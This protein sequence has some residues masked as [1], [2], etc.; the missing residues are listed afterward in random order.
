MSCPICFER[1]NTNDRKPLTLQP[2][3]H[4]LCQVCKLKLR[5]TECPTCR[6]QFTSETPNFA[7]MEVMEQMSKSAE[8]G[9]A[10]VSVSEAPP[11]VPA[12]EVRES[13]E[14]YSTITKC[15]RFDV[16]I[17]GSM[18]WENSDNIVYKNGRKLIQLTNM[19]I[20][21]RALKLF[22]S[23]LYHEIQRQQISPC[24]VTICVGNHK[25]KTHLELT[26][27]DAT[28]SSYATIIRSIDML[29]A[30]GATDMQPWIEHAL[31]TNDE[32]IAS[33][34]RSS[35]EVLVEMETIIFTDGQ[36]GG[37]LG[38]QPIQKGP[39]V[40]RWLEAQRIPESFFDSNTVRVLGF[41][42]NTVTDCETLSK[43]AGL[44][45]GQYLTI[46]NLAEFLGIFA[47]MCSNI[48]SKMKGGVCPTS[49]EKE[50]FCNRFIELVRHAQSQMDVFHYFDFKT[51]VITVL[52]REFPSYMTSEML[53][54][55]LKQLCEACSN[56]GYYDRWGKQ[57]ILS[58]IS[59]WTN[60]QPQNIRDKGCESLFSGPNYGE[61]KDECFKRY[62]EMYPDPVNQSIGNSE[63]HGVTCVLPET[64]VQ[65][66]NGK[67]KMAES[68]QKGDLVQVYNKDTATFGNAK[69]VC[70]VYSN[71]SL[72]EP[73]I[74]LDPTDEHSLI[75]K[76]HP[77]VETDSSKSFFPCESKTSTELEAGTTKRINFVLDS[78]HLL[79]IGTTKKY[80]MFTLGHNYMNDS[81][82]SHPFFGTDKVLQ[83]LQSQ[84]GYEDGEVCVKGGK[85]CPTTNLVNEFVY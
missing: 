24:F 60:R 64:I 7:L 59:A 47:C 23:Q 25:A 79:V 68:V 28:A 83:S 27:L 73:V 85:R 63:A 71:G 66:A 58:T 82:A 52:Q 6:T 26:K 5:S 42:M 53:Q 44:L 77:V 21:M 19:E 35:P 81:V 37:T 40:V 78:G 16:D 56:K 15:F 46:P 51:H 1:Y 84:K 38:G 8:G 62:A 32:I 29:R 43:I 9:G 14:C 20:M 80:A 22:I 54:R 2:C 4:T 65:M 36:N 10:A 13:M 57:Y 41:G 75:T 30:S 76:W 45:R 50:R 74:Q 33:I 61:T 70:V 11:A 12:P 48:I 17:S 72:S 49:D 34:Q 55:D 69:I 3:G 39:D 18:G 31:Q 67:S